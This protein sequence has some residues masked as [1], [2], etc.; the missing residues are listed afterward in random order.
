MRGAYVGPTFGPVTEPPRIDL[1]ADL[2]QGVTDD[3]G[4]LAVVTSA[5][6]ACGYHAGDP[7]P[8]EAVCV[9]AARRGVAVGAQVSYADRAGFGRVRRDVAYDVLR[10]QVA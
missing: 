2:G 3:P 6:V 1:N 4:L 5:N 10:A 8:M 7:A 9:E